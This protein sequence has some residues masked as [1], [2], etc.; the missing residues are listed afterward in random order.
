MSETF[1]KLPE[2][3]ATLIPRLLGWMPRSW[4]SA[5]I[6]HPDHPSRLSTLAHNLL[7]RMG[8]PKA[9]VFDCH[10]P[11]EG[12]RM[13]IDWSR[14]RSFVYGTWEPQ[15]GS[16][17]VFAVKP[18]MVV[19][20]AGAHIG[21]YTLLLAKCVGP[22]GAVFSF[23]PLPSNFEMLQ[24]NVEINNLTHVRLQNEAVFSRTQRITMYVPDEPNP[25]EG[26]LYERGGTR[27]YVVNA[28]SLDDF[29]G[30]SDLRPDVLKIDVEGAEY[31]VL[32]GAQQTISH[33]RPRLFIELHHFDGNLGAHP[34]PELL[35]GYGYQ[36]RWIERW[37]LTSH[38]QAMPLV[39]GKEGS[40]PA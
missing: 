34:V 17:V 25:G 1:Q 19:I 13:C 6:G 24:K 39:A 16:E 40:F 18:G 28:I 30:K 11:L 26:S 4:R 27:Q 22:A 23:E 12:Y 7:N 38:V 32:V 15:V 37:P 2:K 3:Q 10:G 21:Y 5:I 31:D 29:C 35:R 14:F 9:Q 33:W 20:D 8:P 36:V